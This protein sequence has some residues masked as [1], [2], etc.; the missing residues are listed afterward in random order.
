MPYT[1]KSKHVLIAVVLWSVILSVVF[2]VYY[3]HR[4]S[5]YRPTWQEFVA[6][7][8]LEQRDM[9]EELHRAGIAVSRECQVGLEGELNAFMRYNHTPVADEHLR[10]LA[11]FP[12]MN[13]V[14][15]DG[16]NVTDEGL[17]HLTHLVAVWKE[18]KRFS[19]YICRSNRLLMVLVALTCDESWIHKLGLHWIRFGVHIPCC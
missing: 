3:W 11:A 17:S 10:L 9:L 2:L 15:I 18:F 5:Y 14:H 7:Y 1:S 4:R 19:V 6:Q 16:T 8:P 12:F 13:L